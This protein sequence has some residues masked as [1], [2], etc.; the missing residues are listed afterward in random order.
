MGYKKGMISYSEAISRGWTDELMQFLRIE[1]EHRVTNKYN[2][3]G[4][5]VRLYS[6]KK[7]KIAEK[8]AEFLNH[9]KKRR[10]HATEGTDLTAFY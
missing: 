4:S 1:P 2:P 6:F 8:T 7:I 9:H 3:S 10:N 5:Q